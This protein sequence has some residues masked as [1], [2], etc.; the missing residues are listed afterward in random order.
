MKRITKPLSNLESYFLLAASARSCT[1]ALAQLKFA[2]TQ[3]CWK[4]RQAL[5]SDDCKDAEP[6]FWVLLA[7]TVHKHPTSLISFL[8]FPFIG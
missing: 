1:T 5:M 4:P 8:F 7:S 3:I 6:N 2:V